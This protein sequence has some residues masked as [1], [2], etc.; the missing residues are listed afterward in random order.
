M[1]LEVV[2]G[3]LALVAMSVA[4]ALELLALAAKLLVESSGLLALEEVSGE[5]GA[6]QSSSEGLRLRG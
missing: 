4:V 3:M 2:S 5:D 1:V 6:L